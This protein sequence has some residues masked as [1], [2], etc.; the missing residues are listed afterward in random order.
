MGCSGRGEL[1]SLL[2]VGVFFVFVLI[3]D[4]LERVVAE[5]AAADEPLVVL[6]D[7]DAG[8]VSTLSPRT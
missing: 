3:D 7:D 1:A 4:R 6:L 5:V 2:S 8:G